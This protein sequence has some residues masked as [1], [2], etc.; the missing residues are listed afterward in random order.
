MLDHLSHLK[1]KRAKNPFPVDYSSMNLIQLYHIPFIRISGLI[2]RFGLSAL[3][4]QIHGGESRSKI[5]IPAPLPVTQTHKVSDGATIDE[6]S[7]I[8]PRNSPFCAS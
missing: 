4:M 1:K 2:S 3:P 7:N 6:I 8:L 5:P